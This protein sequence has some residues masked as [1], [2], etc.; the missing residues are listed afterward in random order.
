MAELFG[1]AVRRV[2]QMPSVRGQSD[3]GEAQ[4]TEGKC[5]SATA[6]SGAGRP[7]SIK[8]DVMISAYHRREPDA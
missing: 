5:E 4:A 6:A 8:H 3:V 1:D 2:G 7:N